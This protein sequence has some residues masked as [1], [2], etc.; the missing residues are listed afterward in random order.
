MARK[1]TKKEAKAR[2]AKVPKPPGFLSKLPGIPGLATKVVR[3]G[4]GLADLLID[5][6]PLNRT[7][8]IATIPSP[9]PERIKKG[10]NNMNRNEVIRTMVNDTEIKIDA[11]M[12]DVINDDN[13]MM[14]D[15][16]EL[17]MRLRDP[18]QNKSSIRGSR[19]RKK[20]KTD[21][22]MSS[23]LKQANKRMRTKSGKL[24]KGR[25]QADVMKL[26]HKLCKKEMK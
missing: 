8:E 19:K 4:T 12:M 13:I 1:P 7:A 23:C 3:A 26:A 2:L 15:N 6:D 9:V 16:G 14:A 25:T 10:D 21:R 24:R 18:I 11:P 17:M 5:I 20:T 22:V